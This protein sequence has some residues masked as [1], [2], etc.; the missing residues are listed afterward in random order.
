MKY[1]EILHHPHYEPK[2]HP[3]ASKETRAAQFSPFAALTGFDGILTFTA[4]T[5]ELKSRRVIQMTDPDGVS[6][7]V[8]EDL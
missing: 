7:T 1:E 5:H 6:D 3:R 4:K 8:E 2:N